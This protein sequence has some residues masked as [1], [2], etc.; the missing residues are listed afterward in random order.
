[1]EAEARVGKA[2]KEAQA[3]LAAKALEK[4]C[5]LSE[6]EVKTLVM[7]DKW[8]EAIRAGIEGEVQRLTQALANRVK[9]L[10][11]RYAETLKQ[12]E[13]DVDLASEKVEAY[14]KKM[15]LVLA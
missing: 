7:E 12:L 3:A 10:E 5:K 14:L 13:D 9:E 11:E 15:G 2:V 6:A 4:Y 8:L 1:M